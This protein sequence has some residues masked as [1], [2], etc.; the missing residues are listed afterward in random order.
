MCTR[1]SWLPNANP[2]PKKGFAAATGVGQ[3]PVYYYIYFWT[4]IKMG[5]Q[6]ALERW[7]TSWCDL[8]LRGMPSA[9]QQARPDLSLTARLHLPSSVNPTASSLRVKAKCARLS[10]RKGALLRTDQVKGSNLSKPTHTLASHSM[11][12][13]RF[14]K[15]LSALCNAR[16]H[17]RT[18]CAD[19]S[20]THRR[21]PISCRCTMHLGV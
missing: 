13:V 20:M 21:S 11:D 16:M 12:V 7:E 6:A 1:G 2:P 15:S 10:R 3:G 8:M 9:L 14:G 19:C 5:A 17:A 4:L 18:M